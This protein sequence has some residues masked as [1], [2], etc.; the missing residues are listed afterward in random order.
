M[1]EEITAGIDWLSVSLARSEAGY[2]LWRGNVLY[3]LEQ[4]ASDGNTVAER[5][6]L[7]FEGL[8][9]GNCFVG[10]NETLG[11]AQFSGDKANYAFDY[12]MHPRAKVSRL[13]V[14]LTVKTDVMNV[15]E[16]KRCYRG[17]MDN[18]KNIRDGRK[19]KIW[20]IMGSDGGDTCYIGA[21]SSDQRARI[22][23]KEVQSED[24]SYTRCWRYEVV[25]RNELSTELAASVPNED[26]ERAEFCVSFIVDWLSKR[27]VSIPNVVSSRA[28]PL[29]I[30]RT[31]PT[32]VERKLKW[33]REQVRPAVRGLKELGYLGSAKLALG[34]D[35][36]EEPPDWYKG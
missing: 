27:G 25:L 20:I 31:R 15:N 21:A 33:L 35:L 11:Y 8:A 10:F 16:G 5:K 18:N 28:T 7:G 17:A 6:M 26:T 1:I 14:Q 12:A 23:N 29:P 2:T 30:K 34:L 4:V 22:Y 32:D 13:D 24:I 36:E 3:A 19:R 9:S